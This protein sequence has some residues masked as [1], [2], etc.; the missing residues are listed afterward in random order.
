MPKYTIETN[1]ILTPEELNAI[2]LVVQE[3]D[4]AI[5]M[6][7]PFNSA[8]EG[9]AILLEELDELWDEVKKKPND[10]D[11]DNLRKEATQVSAMGLRMVVDLNNFKK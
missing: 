6:Y 4:N 9:Y 8:H 3:Y 11:N 10:R 2:Q 7:E 1:K 5:I